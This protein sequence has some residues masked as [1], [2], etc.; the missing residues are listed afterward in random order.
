LSWTPKKDESSKES[1]L[2]ASLI[3]ALGDLN[4]PE[5]I[6]G[7]RERFQ[8]FLTDRTSL[9]PDLRL[10]VLSVA[11]RYADEATWNKLHELGLK[12]TSI[13]E[14]RNYYEALAS[15]ID[16]K[17]AQKT[18][19][20]SLGDEL[21]TSR[22]IFLVLKVS[23]Q[24]EHPEIAWQ[25]AREHMKDLLAKTD[26]LAVNSYA[27][28]LFTFFSESAR[29]T[30]LEAYAKAN[31]PPAAAKEVAKASDEVAF[32]AEFKARLANQIEQATR[33]ARK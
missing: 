7:C 10:P 2:R 12:T 25:F 21:P 26:A 18:L 8:K 16:P 14:K 9:P 28:S 29:V 11:G 33:P 6:A 32:R 3:S 5:I 23:R 4:D 1:S 27:P 31:L 15:A 24:S 20:I 22:A 30:E 13:E 19:P 17:L